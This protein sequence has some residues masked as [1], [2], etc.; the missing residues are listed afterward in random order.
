[1][2]TKILEIRDRAT[3]IPAMAIKLESENEG[4]RYLLRRAGYSTEFSDV[5]L[6]K[7]EGCDATY[8]PYK[9]GCGA[10]TMQAAHLWIREN[11]DA[12]SDGEVIDVE[13]ILSETD[14]PKLSERIEMYESFGSWLFRGE[15]LFAPL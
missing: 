15:S 10:R 8:D 7:L 6:V 4:Q 14:K 3:F 5:I 2:Q 9:W 13:F 12:L 11:Y 1:M